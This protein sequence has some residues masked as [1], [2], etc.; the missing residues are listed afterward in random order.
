[1]VALQTALDG[2]RVRIFNSVLS[3]HWLVYKVADS[4]VD[5]SVVTLGLDTG[6][7]TRLG[8]DWLVSNYTWSHWEHWEHCLP[9]CL[10]STLEIGE[11]WLSLTYQEY[12]WLNT[13]YFQHYVVRPDVVLVSIY[14]PTWFILLHHRYCTTAPVT[15]R[16]HQYFIGTTALG[17]VEGW[18]D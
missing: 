12:I 11:K 15:T 3:H 5:M 1:M 10:P 16:Y 14:W 2:W 18:A 17:L 7:G 6:P 13:Y 9:A 4:T 8:G